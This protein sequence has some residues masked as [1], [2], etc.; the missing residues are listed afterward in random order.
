MECF[1]WFDGFVLLLL[2]GVWRGLICFNRSMKISEL[3]E[4]V[5]D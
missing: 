2:V 4:V 5:F 1:K 3:F